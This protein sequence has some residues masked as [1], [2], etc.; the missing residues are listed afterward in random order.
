MGDDESSCRRGHTRWPR[1]WS[2][3]VCSSDLTYIETDVQATADGVALVP[4]DADL[5]RVAGRQVQVGELTAADVRAISLSGGE[6]IPTLGELLEE[7][8]DLHF[9]IDLKSDAVVDP[10][11]RALRSAGAAGRVVLAAFSHRRLKRVRRLL[12]EVATSASPLEIAALRLGRAPLAGRAGAGAVPVPRQTQVRR[13]RG[14]NG[15]RSGHD[16]AP[17]GAA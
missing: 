8:A 15:T 12:P 17:R 6:S 16:R 13:R 11:V 1:D 4:H 14:R 9:N 10:A 2:S 7:F 5:S 3:D